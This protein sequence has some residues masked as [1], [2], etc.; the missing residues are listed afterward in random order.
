MVKCWLKCTNKIDC[1]LAI[2]TQ[3]ILLFNKTKIFLIKK[4]YH[5]GSIKIFE[6]KFWSIKWH[7]RQQIKIKN[8]T[9]S[10]QG[11]SFCTWHKYEK[12]E[13]LPLCHI[14]FIDWFHKSWF[15]SRPLCQHCHKLNICSNKIHFTFIPWMIPFIKN[16]FSG[17]VSDKTF[18]IKGKNYY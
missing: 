4:W 12:N 10:L 6:I 14:L 13:T 3:S 15:N 1:L 8:L 17:K 7:L 2:L 9:C 11:F 18:R 16:V 5:E